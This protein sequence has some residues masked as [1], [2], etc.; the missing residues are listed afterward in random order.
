MSFKALSDDEFSARLHEARAFLEGLQAEADARSLLMIG[1][2][3]AAA[4]EHLAGA[5]SIWRKAST[6]LEPW[7]FFNPQGQVVECS[8][9]NSEFG[10]V[11][12]PV[13]H[14]I[15]PRHAA[16]MRAELE[17]RRRAA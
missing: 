12:S 10:H 7:Q 14:G 9:C 13:S 4:K 15:C 2:E 17:Q 8:W 6:K 16:G 5:V 11:P 3:L 1:S